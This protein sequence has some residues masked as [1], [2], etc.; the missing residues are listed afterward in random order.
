[1]TKTG[2]DTASLQAAI[3][4]ALGVVPPSKSASH[5]S[6]RRAPRR[7]AAIDDATESTQASM[8]MGAS[9]VVM[10]RLRLGDGAADFQVNGV[11]RNLAHD[12]KPARF[13]Q[14]ARSPIRAPHVHGAD[15]V[16][17]LIHKAKIEQSVEHLAAKA[18][19]PQGLVPNPD[20]NAKHL[21]ARPDFGTVEVHPLEAHFAD[22]ARAGLEVDREEEA[23]LRHI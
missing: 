13:E 10:G 22:R 12:L 18:V 23:T 8:R 7:S 6:N 15:A 9:S 20:W 1:M 21:L 2:I 16:S 17:A 14:T 19:S 3:I 5:S 4:P 11:K